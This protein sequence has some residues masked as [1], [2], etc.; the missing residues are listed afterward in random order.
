MQ[1]LNE[2]SATRISR[3]LTYLF[4]YFFLIMGVLGPVCLLLAYW[5]KLPDILNFNM[6][7]PL[8]TEKVAVAAETGYSEIAVGSASA[9]MEIS[10]F[11]REFPTLFL[12]HSLFVI[13]ALL[14]VL[15]ILYHLKN[16][17]DAAAEDNV[18]TGQ[19]IRR[20][21]VIAIAIFIVDPLRWIYFN[22]VS[23]PLFSEPLL[24]ITITIPS[25]GYWFIGLLVYF[26]AVVFERGHE[27]YQE[28]KL[29]V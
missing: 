16:L 12:K 27:M 25:L 7:F 3:K 4:W 18:F 19:N 21:K 26:L 24:S 8:N 17:L 1:K 11:A 14:I 2:H 22:L 28:L 13:G 5:G 10:Y 6:A 29:T 20:M 9:S 23:Q 15:T